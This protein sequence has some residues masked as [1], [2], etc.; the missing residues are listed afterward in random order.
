MGTGNDVVI[1]GFVIYGDTP[2]TVLIRGI[3]PRLTDFDVTGVL[4]DPQIDL[5]LQGNP[6]AIQHND[7][8]GGPSTLTDAFR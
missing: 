5:F 1:A 2:I 6:V 4:A 3:G 7:N 8:W